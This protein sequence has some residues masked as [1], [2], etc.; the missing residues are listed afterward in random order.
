[1]AAAAVRVAGALGAR[2]LVAFTQTGETARSLARHRP[3][4]PVL[5][6]TSDPAVRSQL[7]L[8]WDVETFQVPTMGDI[9][10]GLAQVDEV[11]C[12]RGARAGDRVVVLAG[13]PGQAGS[14]HTV[15]IHEVRA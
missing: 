10:H 15:R 6:F 2:A 7:A 8:T 5:A 4:I 1:I 14:T 9:D 13:Q 12:E 3:S 11:M